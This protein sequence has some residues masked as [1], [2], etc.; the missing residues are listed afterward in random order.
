MNITLSAGQV[1]GAEA[2]PLVG[3]K[4]AYDYKNGE[5]GEQVGF[6]YSVLNPNDCCSTVRVKVADVTPIVTQEE[7]DIHSKQLQFA[8]VRFTNFLAKP[9]ASQ[10]SGGLQLSCTAEKAVIITGNSK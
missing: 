1:F 3:I 10:T 2:V 5:R 6:T 4:P 8:M 7:L 9:Y